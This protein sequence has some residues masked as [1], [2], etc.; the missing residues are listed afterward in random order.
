MLQLTYIFSSDKVAKYVRCTFL[1]F[2]STF[3]CVPRSL[4]QNKLSLMQTGSWGIN[5]LHSYFSNR[6]QYTVHKGRSSSALLTK[7]VLFPLVFSFFLH[8]LIFSEDINFVEYSDD[9]T[10]SLPAT[11]QA[12]CS[13]LNSFLSR[14]SASGSS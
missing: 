13:K 2:T 10:V 12:D 11:S 1:D 5:W 7:A 3:K 6:M 8:D 9:L 4:L 14:T